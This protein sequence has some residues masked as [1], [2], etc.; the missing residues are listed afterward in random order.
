MKRTATAYGAY[1]RN[2]SIVFNFLAPHL[3]LLDSDTKRAD[4]L[5]IS[6]RKITEQDELTIVRLITDNRVNASK[7]NKCD[8]VLN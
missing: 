7:K 2:L 4:L 8:S 6:A 5:E 3:Y 1:W